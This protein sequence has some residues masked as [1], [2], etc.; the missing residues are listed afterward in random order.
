MITNSHA[1]PQPLAYLLARHTSPDPHLSGN[2]DWTA[3]MGVKGT[4]GMW[5]DTLFVKV[6]GPCGNIRSA[7]GELRP[8]QLRRALSTTL[9]AGTETS[10]REEAAS[11]E[12]CPNNCVTST[13]SLL[14]KVSRDSQ[15][16]L[17]GNSGARV[18][19]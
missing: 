1:Q 9:S 13:H 8:Q 17:G 19:S 18:P 14:T 12:C 2:K 3:E 10:Q 16:K 7:C 6:F 11:S 15:N 5:K 4:V